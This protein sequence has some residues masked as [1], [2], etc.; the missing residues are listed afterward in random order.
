[1]FP[2]FRQVEMVKWSDQPLP[3]SLLKLESG[4]RAASHGR[5]ESGEMN[6]QAL[7]CF[8]SIQRYMGDQ[9][10]ARDMA[11]VD[12]VYTILMVRAPARF[13]SGMYVWSDLDTPE[14]SK[15]KLAGACDI[16]LNR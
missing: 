11:E 13:P 8:L 9:P 14:L 3:A 15:V 5:L 2:G 12:C 7:D 4:E 1:M 10:M 16:D 6:R